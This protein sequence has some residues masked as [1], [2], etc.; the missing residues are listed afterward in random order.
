[1]HEAICRPRRRRPQRAAPKVNYAELNG[2]D[3]EEEEE[4]AEEEDD[5]GLFEDE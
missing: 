1:M 3:E 5:G 4:D 2:D